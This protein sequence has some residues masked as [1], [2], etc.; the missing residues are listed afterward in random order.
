LGFLLEAVLG[1]SVV[2]VR[3]GE[4]EVEL[5]DNDRD[6]NLSDVLCEGLPK[7]NASPAQEGAKRPRTPFLAIWS[8]EVRTL[9]VESLRDKFLWLLPLFWI[10]LE[11]V[12]WN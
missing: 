4:L 10:I 6:H 12:N 5:G 3:V 8:Q 1:L 2:V 7:A 9:G 11:Q